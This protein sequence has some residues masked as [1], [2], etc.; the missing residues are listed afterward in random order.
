MPQPEGG[1]AAKRGGGREGAGG[2]PC[3]GRGVEAGDGEDEQAGLPG[4]GTT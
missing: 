3:S 2:S 4:K 1:G